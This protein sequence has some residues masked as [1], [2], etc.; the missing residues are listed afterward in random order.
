MMKEE[1]IKEIKKRLD[2]TIIILTFIFLSGTAFAL[3]DPINQTLTEYNNFTR[4]DNVL[5]VAL[6]MN[7]WV[8]GLFGIVTLIGVFGITFITSLLFR[9]DFSKALMFAL[10][11][12][13]ISS[14]FLYVVNFVPDEAVFFSVPLFILSVVYAVVNK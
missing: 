4:A 14:I 5:E 13:T 7:Y 10:F 12:E 1:L 11:I 9:N 2:P 6:E 8:G 3:S